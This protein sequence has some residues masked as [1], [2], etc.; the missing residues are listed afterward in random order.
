VDYLGDMDAAGL[1]IASTA[2]ATAERE[3]IPAGPAEQLWALLVIQPTRPAP[4][5]SNSTARELVA[6]LPA[7]VRDQAHRLLV[8][9]K[10]VPQEALRFDVLRDVSLVA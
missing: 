3:G 8:T 5:T 4:P 2:C 9:G 10:A 6:W 1:Q 7:S